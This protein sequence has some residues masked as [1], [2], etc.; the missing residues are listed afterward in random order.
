M[1]I[2]TQIDRISGNVSAAL[3]AIANKGVTVPDGSASDALAELIASIEAGGGGLP[4]G[5]AAMTTGTYIPESSVSSCKIEHG[6]LQMPD[7]LIIRSAAG[8]P[9]YSTVYIITMA[10]VSYDRIQDRHDIF[11]YA[12]KGALS[13][14]TTFGSNSLSKVNSIDITLNGVVYPINKT[15]KAGTTT[16]FYAGREYTWYAGVFA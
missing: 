5:I 4:E 11:L 7:F 16:N 2:Q 14:E 8:K 6:L 10:V 12:T 15:S 3:T 9:S 1:S 13:G